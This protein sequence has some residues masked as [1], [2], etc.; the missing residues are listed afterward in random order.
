MNVCAVR[1][2]MAVVLVGPGLLQLACGRTDPGKSGDA[3]AADAVA[4][5]KDLAPADQPSGA[6][7]W[8]R[9]D[10]PGSDD[11]G[12]DLPSDRAPGDSTGRADVAA[13]GDL[14]RQDLPLPR[15]ERPL[16][17]PPQRP[18]ALVAEDADAPRFDAGA[19]DVRRA[20]GFL[21]D[22]ADAGSSL[23]DGSAERPLPCGPGGG[24]CNDDPRVSAI[25]GTCQPDGTCAC[26]AGFV[27]NPA[28]GRCRPPLQDASPS[29]DGGELACSGE[30]A[31]CGCGCCGAPRNVA[32]YYPTL[33]ESTADIKAK[34]DAAKSSTNCNLVG[35][36]A[37]TR[38][39]CCLPA[40][41][42]P[43]SA[44]Y[45]ADS[46]VG[47]MYHIGIARSGA[48]CAQISLSSLATSRTGLRIET[49]ASWGVMAASFGACG[50]AST[51]DPVA[52]ALGSVALR[53]SDTACLV[54]VHVTLFAF[55]SAGDLKTAR[56]DVDGL[57]VKDFP[58]TLCK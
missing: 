47:D 48:D 49:P 40:A 35:C 28:T 45:V 17:G 25:W 2:F 32:C 13:P 3:A 15:D 8:A 52:G 16:E 34:D 24:D 1:S 39:V 30:Y 41:P 11:L 56:L 33:G 53:T 26:R 31:A 20:D 29:G 18:D 12:V 51:A 55:T 6:P 42:E 4:A 50:D 36:S 9:A 37:G 46:Y 22:G 38:Y 54:D 21:G 58:A 19:G 43:P 5:G 57:V 44:T 27:I 23:G 14:S 10:Q 7:D